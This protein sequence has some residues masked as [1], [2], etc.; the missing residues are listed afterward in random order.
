MTSKIDYV[1]IKDRDM[2]MAQHALCLG[3]ELVKFANEAFEDKPHS[4]PLECF[5]ATEGHITYKN[6]RVWRELRELERVCCN[7]FRSFWILRERREWSLGLSCAI[8]AGGTIPHRKIQ[9]GRRNAITS[10]HCMCKIEAGEEAWVT[11]HD[12]G[13]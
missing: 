3:N 11:I 1:Y 8:S 10:R 7:I 12:V 5:N 4:S 13:G 9:T 6:V 2:M